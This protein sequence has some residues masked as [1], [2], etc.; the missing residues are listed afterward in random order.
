MWKKKRRIQ[1]SKSSNDDTE[2]DFSS[3]IR[4]MA[5]TRR[6]KSTRKKPCDILDVPAVVADTPNKT[7]W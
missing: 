7:I 3:L 4:I 6:I 5:T 1:L 2:V